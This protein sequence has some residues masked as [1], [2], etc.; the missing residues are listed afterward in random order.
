[1]ELA[2]EKEHPEEET[3]CCSNDVWGGTPEREQ[4]VSRNAVLLDNTVFF[5]EKVR[6]T[7]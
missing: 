5:R 1:M 4:F 6:R 3:A 2:D 7:F